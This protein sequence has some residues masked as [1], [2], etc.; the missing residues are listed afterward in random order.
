MIKNRKSKSRFTPLDKDYPSCDDVYVDFFV[1]CDFETVRDYFSSDFTPT[2]QVTAGKPRVNK[3]GKIRIPKLSHW[4]ISSDRIIDSKDARDHIDYVLDII[5]PQKE[6]I[7][8]LQENFTMGMK[9]VW[10]AKGVSGGPAVWPEQMSR[11]SELNL[12]LGF[13]FYPADW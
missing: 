9:C 4:T 5:Y 7:L 12:E 10:F 11:L 8:K 6:H 13:S 3:T 2:D 1:Y